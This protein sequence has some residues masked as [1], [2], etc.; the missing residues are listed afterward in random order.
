M[1][2]PDNEVTRLTEVVM[3][4]LR[5]EE[6]LKPDEPDHPANYNRAFSA[7]HAALTHAIGLRDGDPFSSAATPLL[8]IAMAGLSHL[9]PKPSRKQGKLASYYKERM[10]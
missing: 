4:V 8:P 2:F 9:T 6:V 5:R 10:P 1:Q 3:A 7:I